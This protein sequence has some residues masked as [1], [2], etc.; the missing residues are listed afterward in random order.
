MIPPALRL[1]IFSGKTS[2]CTF[3]LVGIAFGIE[4]LDEI[5]RTPLRLFLCGLGI[6][7][8]IQRTDRPR[9]FLPDDIT[10][11]SENVQVRIKK[12]LNDPIMDFIAR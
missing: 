11:K 10:E 8:R 4:V 3:H 2:R 7:T 12:I 1:R 5:L 9:H 6:F